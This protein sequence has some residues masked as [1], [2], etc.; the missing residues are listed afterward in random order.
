VTATNEAREPAGA[1]GQSGVAGGETGEAGRAR[2]GLAADA[3][4]L[5][6]SVFDYAAARLHLEG[7]RLESRGRAL[8]ARVMV[9]VVAI[10]VA[11]FGLAFVSIGLA[12]LISENLGSRPAGP[13]IVGG[14]YMLAGIVAF[15]IAARR[16]A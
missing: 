9:I 3:V 14:V 12:T 6:E 8:A 1:A 5:V 11:L 4:A 2:E 15:A 7:Y 10:A 16:K 13:L